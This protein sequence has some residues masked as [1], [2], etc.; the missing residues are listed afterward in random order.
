MYMA[1]S[2]ASL[3]AALEGCIIGYESLY[4]RVGMLQCDISLDNLIVNDDADNPSWHAFFDRLGP[5]YQERSRETVRGTREDQHAS[6]H[7]D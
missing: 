7:G 1:S 6:V 2:R 5:C 3:L 4:K